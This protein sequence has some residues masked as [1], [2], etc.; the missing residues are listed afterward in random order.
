[1]V[2]FGHFIAALLVGSFWITVFVGPTQAEET[3]ALIAETSSSGGCDW[4]KGTGITSSSFSCIVVHQPNVEFEISRG[5]IDD[6]VRTASEDGFEE[7]RPLSKEV[8][9]AF[10]R[11][12]SIASAYFSFNAQSNSNMTPE[13]CGIYATTH[14][15]K[16]DLSRMIQYAGEGAACYKQIHMLGWA[17]ARAL[18][19]KVVPSDR[20]NLDQ[21]MS[22]GQIADLTPK[23]NKSILSVYEGWGRIVSQSNW[24]ET[25]GYNLLALSNSR[26]RTSYTAL[27]LEATGDDPSQLPG[28]NDYITRISVPV[29]IVEIGHY[30]NLSDI[31]LKETG[32]A[33]NWPSLWAFNRET[34]R[35]PNLIFAGKKI[36]IPDVEL[37]AINPDIDFTVLAGD[38]FYPLNLCTTGSTCVE[39]YIPKFLS[40]N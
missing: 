16:P 15:R 30:Q 14:V 36:M 10:A 22:E 6:V 13:Q 3:E 12:P 7:A 23:K 40:K 4:D 20:H 28:A 17:M 9:N 33:D 24:G 37:P 2:T 26:I 27:F 32:K 35:D 25:S 8:Q 1:M 21:S 5:S 38:K 29:K 11:D 34:V 18:D 19:D 31:A 39:L